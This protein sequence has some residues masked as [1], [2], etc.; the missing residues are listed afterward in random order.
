MGAVLSFQGDRKVVIYHSV[1]NGNS[2]DDESR[3]HHGPIPAFG[4]TGDR[5]R[6]IHSQSMNRNQTNQS[7]NK[8]IDISNSLNQYRFGLDEND[9]NK[10]IEISRNNSRQ[11]QQNHGTA[12]QYF[13]NH[14]GGLFHH[15]DSS[16]NH[17]QQQQQQGQRRQQ[18]NSK[19]L[20]H[21]DDYDDEVGDDSSKFSKINSH[22]TYQHNHPV[23]NRSIGMKKSLNLLSLLN[24]GKHFGFHSSQQVKSRQKSATN[25]HQISWL[26][27]VRES[28]TNAKSDGNKNSINVRKKN[29]NSKDSVVSYDV[30]DGDGLDD[31]ERI[32]SRGVGMPKSFSC[33]N[34]KS[35][36]T[37]NNLELVKS[38]N[39]I[40]DELHSNKTNEKELRRDIDGEENRSASVESNRSDRKLSSSNSS[41]QSRSTTSSNLAV[42][43]KC[44]II[45]DQSNMKQQSRIKTMSF[46][47]SGR[48]LS[49]SNQNDCCFG[50]ID[51]NG[52]SIDNF[53]TND[54]Y[55]D[56]QA[57]RW[58]L[59]PKHNDNN[60][61]NHHHHKSNTSSTDRFDPKRIHHHYQDEQKHPQQQKYSS[62]NLVPKYLEHSH[63]IDKTYK[64]NHSSSYKNLKNNST[65]DSNN[66]CDDG[67]GKYRNIDDTNYND[68]DR[69][70]DRNDRLNKNVE[71][72]RDQKYSILNNNNGFA[73]L[74]R[75]LT[76]R[77]IFVG[78]NLTIK[79]T[80]KND[81]YTNGNHQQKQQQQHQQH[82]LNKHL[83]RLNQQQSNAAHQSSSV[84]STVSSSSSSTSSNSS[85]SNHQMDPLIKANNLEPIGLNS[86]RHQFHHNL[87]Q[88]HQYHLHQLQQQQQRQRQQNGG[89]LSLLKSQRISSLSS[90]SES[91]ESSSSS[92]LAH[93]LSMKSSST[94]T[95][96]D[97]NQ[98]KVAFVSS[99]NHFTTQRPQQQTASIQKSH[100][101]VAV[102][103]QKRTV[104]QLRRFYSLKTIPLDH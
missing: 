30:D 10:K 40:V 81:P 38:V 96:I 51:Y 49:Q 45:M 64:D 52:N 79:R 16:S 55:S 12:K 53:E 73:T 43:K 5:H 36:T 104:I 56:D 98:T 70:I 77:S 72:F 50:S 71:Y 91:S 88:Q 8:L 59:S 28:R 3:I 15:I 74:Q 60:N 7:K 29:R 54:L 21:L 39:K 62:K 90:S 14:F 26:R 22:Q 92:S 102:P 95:V 57:R 93:S 97:T 65:N 87:L 23:P 24:I 75:P 89:K 61:N 78:N 20:N 103:H 47:E 80:S 6:H 9:E 2:I 27:T 32:S 86:N 76:H 4:Y 66:N 46:D 68:S 69:N 99:H 37:T 11:Q 101:S 35:G 18:R 42:K 25:K 94:T 100:Q 67:N 58:N 63:P 31:S 34:L 83:L 13:R 1:G 85:G 82:N 84:T 48:K 17:H 33:Y 44:M 19:I 41:K